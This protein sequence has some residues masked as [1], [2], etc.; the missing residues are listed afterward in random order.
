MATT[1]LADALI[2]GEEGICLTSYRDTEGNWTIGYGHLLPYNYDWSG[3]TISEMEA[4]VLLQEDIRKAIVI[5]SNF[6]NFDTMDDVRQAVLVSMCFQMGKKP[7]GWPL[8]RSAV[9]AGNWD[10]A[11][12]AGLDTDWHRQT[13]ARCERE[14]VM[15]RTGQWAE[16]A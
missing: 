6:S 5:A 4:E 10:L 15:L 2:R 1:D 7:L 11:A 14:M 9:Q 3:H 8:F 12:Q 16:S 13:P